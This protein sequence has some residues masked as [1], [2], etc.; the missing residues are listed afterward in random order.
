MDQYKYKARRTDNNEW[1]EGYYMVIN[2]DNMLT[3]AIFT[4]PGYTLDK[5]F[6]S[7]SWV[8][9]DRNTLKHMEE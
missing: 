4:G 6:I 2:I 1:V 8:R 9:I 5:I 7:R 3:D